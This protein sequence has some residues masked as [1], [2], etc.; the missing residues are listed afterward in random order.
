MG[1][2]VVKDSLGKT[3]TYVRILACT[4]FLF[5]VVYGVAS[6]A[7][8]PDSAGPGVHLGQYHGHLRLLLLQLLHLRGEEFSGICT[9]SLE[10]SLVHLGWMVEPGLS[11]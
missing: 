6:L 10:D 1:Y 3:M 11:I 5:G 2:G 7:I 8:T 9:E 4:H